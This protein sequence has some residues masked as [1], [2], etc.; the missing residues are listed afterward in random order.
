LFLTVSNFCLLQ[1]LANDITVN[2]D[3]AGLGMDHRAIVWCHHV[4]T[5]VREIL[6]VMAIE[7]GALERQR[8]LEMI[9]SET[10]YL[11]A[12]KTQRVSFRVSKREF[13]IEK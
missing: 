4:L 13:G 7:K 3:K 11:H 10:D 6:H 12:V 8:R 2:S 5:K 1:L 9:L